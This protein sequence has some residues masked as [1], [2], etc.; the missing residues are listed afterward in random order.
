[1]PANTPCSPLACTGD[2]S[3]WFFYNDETDEVDSSL[4]AF[5]EGP[6]TPPEGVGSAQISVTGSQRRNIATYQ[7]AGTPLSDITELKFSTYNPSAGNGG[8]ADRT[9]Y[10]NFNVSFDGLDTWQ[11]RLSYHPA[12]NGTIVQDV[13]QE[14]DAIDGG[15]ALWGWSGFVANGNQW[16]DGETATLRTWSDLLISFPNIQIRD[17]DSWF[18]VRV[19]EPYADGYTENID[20]IVFGTS[21]GTTIFDFEPYVSPPTDPDGCHDGGWQESENPEFDSERECVIYVV[22][23][24]EYDSYAEMIRTLRSELREL[25]D[26][27]DDGG[28]SPRRRG[29]WG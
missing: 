24:G 4:G 14:W 26:F 1:M 18:G 15:N 17:T 8:A 12:Q 11:R 21:G 5:V 23:N 10:L 2:I 22:L 27:D 7:F 28:R 3:G 29:G 9:G 20:K 13:W 16:P 19:G 25:S 6:A